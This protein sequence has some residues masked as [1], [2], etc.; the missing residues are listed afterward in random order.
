VR[1]IG[2]LLKAFLATR[3]SAEGER[4]IELVEAWRELAGISA[5]HVRVRDLRGKVLVLEADHPGWAQLVGLRKASYLSS[6]QRR[7]PDLEIQDIRLT[8]GSGGEPAGGGRPRVPPAE[9]PRKGEPAR[10]EEARSAVPDKGLREALR[11]LYEKADEGGEV[12]R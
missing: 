11:A 4:M 2:D 8:V 12:D 6:L 1:R 7:F 5:A 9:P 3:L 10:I